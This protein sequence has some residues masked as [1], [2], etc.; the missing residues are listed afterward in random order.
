M[1]IVDRIRFQ[2]DEHI[3][4][5]IASALRQRGID[6]ITAREARLLGATD[7]QHLA[8]AYAERRVMVTQDDDFLRLH[9]EQQPHA[10]IA[11]CKQGS[12]SIGQ[13]IASLVLLHEILE[14]HEIAGQI[15]YL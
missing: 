3:S 13:T 9:H 6:V 4:P 2:L 7:M 1:V 12:R 11:Y 15:E 14:P 8:R 10:G 5:A